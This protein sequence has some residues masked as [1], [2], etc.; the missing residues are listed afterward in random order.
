MNSEN[1]QTWVTN[2]EV[3]EEFEEWMEDIYRDHW[4]ALIDHMIE[5]DLIDKT[6][7]DFGC[8]RG[9][10][11]RI[12]YAQKPFAHGYG[13]DLDAEAIRIANEKQEDLPLIYQVSDT[14]RHLVDVIDVAFSHEVLYLLKDLDQHA[15][16]MFNALNVNGV[17][18]AAF[19][20][21]ADSPAWQQV[22]EW[23][24]SDMGVEP[25]DYT[26]YQITD[27]FKKQGFTVQL[28]KFKFD[29]FLPMEYFKD[30]QEI[31]TV[32]DMLNYYSEYKVLFRFSK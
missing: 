12:L 13:I 29:G 5:Q 1:T 20:N 14:I 6:V 11:L 31:W 18:Y 30:T 24:A 8:N 3:K 4:L 26:L 21:H 9:T 15:R 16:E 28:C 19:A 32:F 25:Q 7:L 17:Y 2:T 23:F 22:K 27:I 10:L